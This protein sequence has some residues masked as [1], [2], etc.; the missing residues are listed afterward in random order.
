MSSRQRTQ[1]PTPK[2]AAT[3]AGQKKEE[4]PKPKSFFQKYIA[5]NIFSF[6]PVASLIGILHFASKNNWEF[7]ATMKNGGDWVVFLICVKLCMLHNGLA[8]L[9]PKCARIVHK[10]QG[11]QVSPASLMFENELGAVCLSL[12]ICAFLAGDGVAVATI[13]KA[14]GGFFFY[15]AARHVYVG[16]PLGTALGGIGT[17][18]FLLLAGFHAA[19]LKFTLPSSLSAAVALL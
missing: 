15:A 7:D 6:Y 5:P 16:Q 13:S 14:V 8:H 11:L 2:S 18:V 3:T 4:P 1:T 9:I 10:S 17:C 12:S 19:P